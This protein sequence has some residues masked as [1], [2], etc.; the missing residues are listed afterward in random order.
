[1]ALSLME[2]MN[3]KG[4]IE[5]EFVSV[6]KEVTQ[7]GEKIALLRLKEPIPEVIGSQKVTDEVTGEKENYRAFGVDIVRVH[8]SEF[9]DPNC[10][11]EITDEKTG[12]GKVNSDFV[13]DVT[14]NG[15]VFLRKETIQ[16][17]INGQRDQKRKEKNSGLFNKLSAMKVNALAKDAVTADAGKPEPVTTP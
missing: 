9:T 1:M 16:A 17:W 3:S 14:S 15:D 4:K 2:F 5:F 13:L 8:Q 11:I 6:A 12:A 10:G 7:K